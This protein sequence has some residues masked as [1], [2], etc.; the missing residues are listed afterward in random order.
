MKQVDT[1]L[2][3]GAGLMG[4]GIAQAMAMK[5]INVLIVDSN[6]KFLERAENWIEENLDYMIELGEIN[7]AEKAA[8]LA[9]LSLETDLNSAAAKADFIFEAVSENLELK[10]D[11]FRAIDA[12]ADRTV[13]LATNTSSYDINTLATAVQHKERVIG[14]HWFHPPHIT[15]CVEVIPSDLT[16]RE[17]LDQALS[18]MEQ[19]GKYPTPCQSAPGFVANRIQFAMAAEAFAIVE[20]GLASPEEVDRIVKSSFG[21]RL[22]G[23]G[24]FEISDQAGADT[25][26]AIY[27]YLYE[28]LGREQ[29]K[30][31]RILQELVA[32]GKFGIKSGAGFY[33]YGNGAAVKIKRERDRKFFARLKLF[34]GDIQDARNT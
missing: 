19:I 3:I 9:R 13:V 23:F 16:S 4:H 7:T 32:A 27:E 8:T 6:E 26:L 21:F 33:D 5:G 28:K 17:V 22:G 11:V 15:P 1:A 10:L 18:F 34:N 25:Y 29:F 20:E 31:P 24:P 2:V 14:I 30:P 12:I